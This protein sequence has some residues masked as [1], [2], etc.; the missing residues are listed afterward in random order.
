MKWGGT[1]RKA[2]VRLGG[3]FKAYESVQGE[4]GGQ[5]LMTFERTYF[6]NGPIS[7][8][9]PFIYHGVSLFGT[10]RNNLSNYLSVMAR[11]SSA[12][13]LFNFQKQNGHTILNPML[14]F[15]KIFILTFLTMF[16]I[17]VWLWYLL[18]YILS[19][20]F[21]S[22]WPALILRPLEGFLADWGTPFSN[23][24]TPHQRVLVKRC[25]LCQQRTNRESQEIQSHKYKN[26]Q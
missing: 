4:G 18:L 1:T 2:Y 16:C 13:G 15:F 14:T 19:N 5:I 12:A 9:Q 17:S 25:S 10:E 24:P 8:H 26:H 21:I 22:G 11:A 3:T 7:R 20:L 23:L 6:L